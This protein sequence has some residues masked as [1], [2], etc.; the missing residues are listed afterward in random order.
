VPA[1]R[2]KLD[3]PRASDYVLRPQIGAKQQQEQPYQLAHP[4]GFLG[5][6]DEKRL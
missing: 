6:G 2:E 1:L 4:A 5:C 3:L